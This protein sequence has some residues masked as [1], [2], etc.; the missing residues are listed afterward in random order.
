MSEYIIGC[1][2]TLKDQ[3]WV[4]YLCLDW[5]RWLSLESA[6]HSIACEALSF[7]WHSW[8]PPSCSTLHS[9]PSLRPPYSELQGFPRFSWT[10]RAHPRTHSTSQIRCVPFHQRLT[11][12][13][14]ELA[15][16]ECFPSELELLI[17][18]GNRSWSSHVEAKESSDLP[19]SQDSLLVRP[20]ARFC[21][22]LHLLRSKAP[23]WA[24][25][26]RTLPQSS[27]C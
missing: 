26:S 8:A 22:C 17:L 13:P 6:L 24:C 27:Y 11:L 3:V 14:A 4:H 10:L 7:P 25:N 19:R 1:V 21:A 9:N 20:C 23:A 5:M 16:L 15:L 18:A 12:W 2:W